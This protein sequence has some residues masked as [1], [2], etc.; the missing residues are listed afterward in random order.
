MVRTGTLI[1]AASKTPPFQ[2]LTGDKMCPQQCTAISM[3]KVFHWTRPLPRQTPWC[4]CVCQ[5]QVA[6]LP[7]VA[8]IGVLDTHHSSCSTAGWSPL[9]FYT[10]VPFCMNLS[11]IPCLP[12]LFT[13]IGYGKFEVALACSK[14]SKKISV[15]LQWNGEKKFW[16]K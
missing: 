6:E 3:S 8:I 16:K 4:G 7:S 5:H 11:L 13:S 12:A 1:I 10:E 14:Y 2:I 9:E 15:A